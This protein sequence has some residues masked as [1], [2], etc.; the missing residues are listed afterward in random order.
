MGKR[1]DKYV[2]FNLT[3]GKSLGKKN[4][5]TKIKPYGG[6]SKSEEPLKKGPVEV[7]KQCSVG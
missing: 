5:I 3:E 6:V 1:K 4:E 2:D 7:G